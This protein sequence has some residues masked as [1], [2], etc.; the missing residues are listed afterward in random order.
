MAPT[1]RPGYHPGFGGRIHQ[2]EWAAKGPEA[3]DDVAFHGFK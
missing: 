1:R 2:F 3:R